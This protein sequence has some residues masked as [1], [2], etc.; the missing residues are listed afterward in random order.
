MKKK[1][2]L[3]DIVLIICLAAPCV[4]F[5]M[6]FMIYKILLRRRFQIPG[7]LFPKLNITIR[8]Y[9][10]WIII[11]KRFSQRGGDINLTK[12]ILNIGENVFINKGYS[13]NIQKKISIGDGTIIGHNF[14][15]IDHDHV[16]EDFSISRERFNSKP[17]VIGRDVWIG[18]NVSILKGVTVGD[19]ATIAAGSLVTKD[20]PKHT[21]FVQKRV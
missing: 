8:S 11:G 16:Q 7:I 1:K 21:V 17:V 14:F 6:K 4:S 9:C 10:S 3:F 12:G 13:I 19:G 15:A 2:V 18:A 5:A 20:I